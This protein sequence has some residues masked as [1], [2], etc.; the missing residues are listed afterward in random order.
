MS[1]RTLTKTYRHGLFFFEF[2]NSYMVLSTKS[3]LSDAYEKGGVVSVKFSKSE[4]PAEAKIV[5][6]SGR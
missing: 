1:L 2:D 6:L 3:I 4:D 5:E